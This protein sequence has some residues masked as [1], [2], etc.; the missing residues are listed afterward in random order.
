MRCRAAVALSLGLLTAC[1]ATA[2]V[3]PR[4]PP[5]P[6]IE[7]AAGV[8][9]LALP[10]PTEGRV[11]LSAWID[12][13]SRD[14]SPPQLAVVSAWA[15]APE[16]VEARTLADGIELSRPCEA[17]EEALVGCLGSLGAALGARRVAPAALDAAIARARNARRRAVVDPR[18]TADALALSALFGPGGDP[19]GDPGRDGELDGAAVDGFLADHFGPGRTLIVAVG[20]VTPDSLRRAAARALDGLPEARR[21]RA[22]REAPSRR[23]EVRVADATVTSVATTFETPGRAIAAARRFVARVG[24]GASAEVF[25]VRGGTAV[26]VRGGAADPSVLID[27]VDELHEEPIDEAV[28]PVPEDGRALARWHGARWISGPARSERGLGVGAVLDG[29]R[30]DRLVDDPDATTR[31]EARDRLSALVAASP[32]PSGS[33]GDDRAEVQLPNH[34]RIAAV[35]LPGTENVAVSVLFEGGAREETARSHGATALLAAVASR[36]CRARAADELGAPAEALGIAIRP[37]VGPERFGLTVTGPSARWPE[38]TYLAA[39]CAR[40]R[41]LEAAVVERARGEPASEPALSALAVALS[42][43]APG[44]IAVAPSQMVAVSRDELARWRDRVAV[45]GRARIGLA[46]DV[47]LR[48][49]V[50]RLARIVGRYPEGSRPVEDRWD[51]PPQSLG[52]GAGSRVAAWIVWS[53]PASAVTRVAT[54]RFCDAAAAAIRSAGTLRVVGHHH[55][56]TGGRAVAA[57]LVEADETTLGRLP[58]LVPEIAAEAGAPTTTSVA[59]TPSARALIL[60]LAE[61]AAAP[62]A[63]S[64]TFEA[65]R[66]AAPSFVVVRPAR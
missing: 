2:R 3:E 15:V 7:E 8:R 24:E 10:R 56:V 46:G 28:V 58:E 49:A 19:F 50:V 63:S 23:A 62:E 17:G 54:S 22:E 48:A 59:A 38:V 41:G 12:A 53:S 14:A 31:D 30:G 18:R 60:A 35:R 44:R 51:G 61:P 34:A 21:A 33:I 4:V 57:V 65:L 20:D 45:G 47:P 55:V 6:E 5:G 40:P 36:E 25:P 42:P 1:G 43:E 9:L 26:L 52:A 16:G 66:R 64:A 11:W 32:A 27:R 29:G 39:R 13:G 37:H